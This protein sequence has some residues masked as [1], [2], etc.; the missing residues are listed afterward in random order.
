M[1]PELFEDDPV[2]RE[3]LVYE[4]GDNWYNQGD[5]MVKD[6]RVSETSLQ[7]MER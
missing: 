3:R 7:K 6:L 5:D 1:L 4:D 2:K